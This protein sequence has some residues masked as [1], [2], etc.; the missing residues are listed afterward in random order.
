MDTRTNKR[1][2]ICGYTGKAS[3]GDE[4]ILDRYAKALDGDIT[5]ITE[6]QASVAAAHRVRTVGRYDISGIIREMKRS[7]LLILGGGTL[8]QRKTS[9]RSLLYYSSIAETAA[10]TGL[11]FVVCGGI[12]DD[13]FITQNVLKRAKKLYLRDS[14]SVMTARRLGFADKCAYAPDPVLIPSVKAPERH[15]AVICSP[16]FDDIRS[17]KAALYYSKAARTKLVFLSMNAEDDEICKSAAKKCGAP[18][19]TG[20]NSQRCEA[21]IGGA[22]ALFTSRLHACVMAYSHGVPFAVFSD[23]PKITAFAH[24]IGMSRAVCPKNGDLVNVIDGFDF[25]RARAAAQK[26]SDALCDLQSI[27]LS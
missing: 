20:I 22:G 25:S 11:P 3:A 13:S 2:L 26:A 19:E 8:L 27:L 23:D 24:D 12:D 1:C 5:V 7:D 17:I 6:N 10:I 14:F 16:R 4:A 18:Y 9:A 21:L 15:G